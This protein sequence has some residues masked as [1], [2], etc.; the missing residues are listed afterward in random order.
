MESILSLQNVH[1]KL[2][3]KLAVNGVSLDVYP[4]EIYG[5]LG[6]NGAGKTTTIRMITGLTKITS[7]D[8]RIADASIT[9]DYKS[10]IQHVGTIVENPELYPY[11]TA[12]KNLLHFARM[13]KNVTKE[14]I[15]SRLKLVRL[16]HVRNQKVRKFSLGMKQRLGIAQALIHRPKVLILD[17][18]T[19]G[20]D[21]AG[22]REMRDYLRKVA[23]E[24]GVAIFISSHLL[25]EIE[26]ICDRFA[27]IQEGK[28]VQVERVS[29][30]DRPEE[31]NRYQL[32]VSDLA[33]AHK[34][35]VREFPKLVIHEKENWLHIKAAKEQVGQLIMFLTSQGVMVYQSVREKQTL[36]DRFLQATERGVS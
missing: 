24:E 8:I 21:P 29:D 1:K 28:L 34:L 25:A 5:F 31:M 15:D 17:E 30:E 13:S 12:E 10:A 18:P 9:S 19:N 36:E 16:D 20:L 3:K 27:I 35:A 32:E 7:G 14:D 23:K 6:P 2:G 22:V 26:L 11:L 33:K 4:G